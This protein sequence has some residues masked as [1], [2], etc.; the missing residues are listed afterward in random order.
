MA[1][2]YDHPG[3]YLIQVAGHIETRSIEQLGA[4]DRMYRFDPTRE[5]ETVTILV[6]SL[7]DQAALIGMLN[8][9]YNMRFPLLRV[10]YLQPD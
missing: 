4:L 2:P 10:E 5:H 9:L 3:I 6:G 1:Q 7:P 8:Q